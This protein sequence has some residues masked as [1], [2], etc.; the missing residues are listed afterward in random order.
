MCMVSTR[1]SSSKKHSISISISIWCKNL[2]IKYALPDTIS[3]I[4]RARNMRSTHI[5][6]IS[7]YRIN[8]LKRVADNTNAHTHTL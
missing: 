3:C 1:S 5:Q 7:A 8:Y 6:L 4:V 2:T